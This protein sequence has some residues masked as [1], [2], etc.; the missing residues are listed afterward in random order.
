V[1]IIKK[2]LDEVKE[3]TQSSND[4]AFFILEKLFE[5][6]KMKLE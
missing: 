2:Q 1:Q 6:R 3:I 4:V 5:R